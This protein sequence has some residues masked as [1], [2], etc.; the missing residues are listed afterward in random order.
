MDCSPP[1]SSV[2]EIFQ[3]R[4][5]EWV[6]MPFS[7]GIFLAQGSNLHLMSP[8]LAGSFFTTRVTWEAHIIYGKSVCPVF[9][10]LI[11]GNWPWAP[12]LLKPPRLLW[13]VIWVE[14]H[15]PH[16]MVKCAKELRRHSLPWV[17][18]YITRK[19]FPQCL[20][21]LILLNHR[22]LLIYGFKLHHFQAAH[23]G[24]TQIPF[25]W[26]KYTQ[27]IAGLAPTACLWSWTWEVNT[28]KPKH[29]RW[30]FS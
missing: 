8:A 5:L 21:W 27:S 20:C 9:L 22:A 13:C 18:L 6:A 2:H 23:T 1:G 10:N 28:V 14:T 25:S 4:I 26:I 7:R 24:H 16:L 3:A 15:C 11:P 17:S 30:A 19:A 29:S 12:V